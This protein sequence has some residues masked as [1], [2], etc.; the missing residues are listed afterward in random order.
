MDA[1]LI[2][3]SFLL[4]FALFIMNR[5]GEIIEN[6]FENDIQDIPMTVLF[7]KNEN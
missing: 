1:L 4:S 7:K 2:S 3:V 6:P 5:V